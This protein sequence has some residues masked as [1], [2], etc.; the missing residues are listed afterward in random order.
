MKFFIFLVCNI[1]LYSC[2]KDDLPKFNQI[3]SLRIIALTTPTPEVNPGDGVTITPFVS[4]VNEVGSL[5][6]TAYGCVDLGIAYGVLPNCD[7][8]PTK[9]V[10]HLN[11]TLILPSLIPDNR[12]GNAD[13]F[14][15]AVPNSLIIFNGKTSRDQFNG[16]NYLVEYILTNSMGQQIKS[17]KRIV[18]STKTPKNSNPVITDIFS[19]GVSM[20]TLPIS[21]KTNLTTDLSSGSVENYQSQDSNNVTQT[22]S[23]VVSI[24]WFITDGETK[25]FRSEI[26]QSNEYT[27]PA[28]APTGRSAYVFAVARDNRG[29]AT[30]LQKKF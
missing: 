15:F 9:T 21:I 7:N 25:F 12:T 26:G 8:N 1:I 20:T 18:V 19:N 4:D 24:T 17:F 22:A 23:E 30:V 27:G 29:G 3:N 16:V 13:T 14:S 5:S 10:I 2:S 6:D 28:T 11:R